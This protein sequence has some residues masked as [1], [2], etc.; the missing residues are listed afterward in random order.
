MK[1]MVSLVLALVL[2][3]ALAV[4]ALA[5]GADLSDVKNAPNLFK[6]EYPGTSA[7]VTTTLS[8]EARAYT[9]AHM[10][11]EFFS[12]TQFSL[13]VHN[14]GQS[15]E[16]ASFVL[17]IN[18]AAGDQFIN[19]DS[20]SFIIG[21]KEYLFE[22]VMRGTVEKRDNS[23]LEQGAI[24]ISISALDFLTAMDRELEKGE[25]A[26]DTVQWFDDHPVKMVLHGDVDVEAMLGAG[27]YLD[28]MGVSSAVFDCVDPSYLMDDAT[29]SPL[30]VK[31]VR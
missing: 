31:D 17:S 3:M 1:K 7:K 29:S 18:Y 13:L 10:G 4:P 9:H 28:F 22:G 20:V 2:V 5:A 23:Y 6:I 24:V 25:A 12:T 16:D 15:N 30:T 19:F 8:P 26:E 21:D 11:N 14:Y 27:F